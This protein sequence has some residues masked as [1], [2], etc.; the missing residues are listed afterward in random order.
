[1]KD[2]D[3]KGRFP[4][5]RW[6]PC[7]WLFLSGAVLTTSAFPVTFTV[8]VRGPNNEVVPHFRWLV[9]EDTTLV[10][11]PGQLALPGRD[12]AVSF[13]SSYCPPVGT[14]NETSMPNLPLDPAKRYYLS[15]QPMQG[16]PGSDYAIGG[17]PVVATAGVFPAI[18]T[19]LVQPLPLPTAQIS[20]FV[21]RDDSPANC[22]PDL[23][24]EVGLPG[25][26]V[27]LYE[28]GGTY[29]ASGGLVQKDAWSNPLGTTYV[30]DVNGQAVLGPDGLPIIDQL[31]SGDLITDANGECLIKN[32]FQ[33]KYSV[34]I[35]P[36]AGQNWHETTT[37]EGT[38]FNDAWVKANEPPYFQEFGPPGWHTFFGFVQPKVDTTVLAPG[39]GATINGR[40]TNLHMSRPPDYRF[41]PG[42]PRGGCWVA[43]HPMTGGVAGQSVY[44][45]PCDVNL[46][47]FSIPN[48]PEGSWSLGIWDDNLLQIFATQTVIVTAAD[49]TS[50]VKNVGD[51]SVYNW[52]HRLQAGVFTDNGRDSLDNGVT[53]F[54]NPAKAENGFWD[55][56]EQGIPET[57][58]NIRFRDGSI[59]M[60]GKTDLS[61]TFE[62][63][64]VF[65]FF[66]WMVAEVDYGKYKP[67]GGTFIVDAGGPVLPD[68]GWTYPSFD[69]LTPQKQYETDPLTGQLIFPLV[70]RIN[71]NTGNNLSFT[72]TMAT[73]TFPF[74]LQA[75]QGF[76]G[77]TNVFQW[78]KTQY[79]T[80]LGE[81]GGITGI[82]H[83]AIT[84]AEDDPR[85]AVAENWEPGIPRV[86]V[87]LYQDFNRDGIIDDINAPAGIQA[88]DVDNYPF[89]WTDPLIGLKGTEDVD[90][91]GDGVFDF[92][93]A[94]QVTWTDSWD[95]SKPTGAQPDET[96]TLY[97]MNGQPTDAYD[98][99]RN[100]NQIRPGVFDG[101]YSFQGVDGFGN[102][103]PT[104]P[105]G[106]YIVESVTP[107]G[108]KHQKEEDKN[109]V[110]GDTY[111]P[112]PQQPQP[113]C[114]GDLHLVPPY[115]ALFPDLQI[116]CY[117][118]G[119]WRPGTDR[120]QITVSPG[121]NAACDFSMFTEVPVAGH[122]VGMILDDLANEFNPN[123]PAFGEK[124]APPWIPISI[125]D[126]TGREIDRVY[127][128]E[129][130][131][132]NC[133]VPST[134]TI[135]PPFP[136][137]VS[138]NMI[139]VSLNDPG[140][141]PDPAHPGQFITDPYF[142]RQYS[143]FSYTFQ[144]LPGKTTYLD[145]PVVPT[146]AFTGP[147]QYSLDCEFPDGTPLIYA[148]SGTEYG[149]GPFV[150]ST[151]R[152]ITIT[153]LGST[154]VPN[155][156]Y[157]T[158]GPAPK[159]INRDYGFG[160]VRGEVTINGVAL[161]NVIW[162][163][164]SISGMVAAGTTTG[165]LVIRR[166]D[167][168]EYSPVGVTVT[169]GKINGR[170]PIA[171]APGGSIQAAID[172]AQPNDLILVAPGSYDQLP[173]IRKPV[174]LQG[175]GAG[176]T[177]INAR[178]TPAEKLQAWRNKIISIVN[179]GDVD[180]LP[181]Q[182]L[183]P[184]VGG[185]PALLTTEEGAG[186]TVLS[187]NA[188][189][190]NGGFGQNPRSRIDGFT[191]TGADHGGA[192]FVNG[193]A[194][195]L[196]IS[197]NRIINNAGF[198]GG[199]IRVGHPELVGDTG[200][201]DAQND[202]ILIR[203]NHIAEN[204]GQGGVGGGVSLCPGSTA[205]QVVDNFICGN[206]NQGSGGGIGHLGFNDGGLIARNTI[207]FNECF[208]QATYPTG[209]GIYVGG[210]AVVGGA[211]ALTLGTGNVT[212]DSN[213]IQGNE[214]GAG[215][216]GG[217][218]VE[219]ANGADVQAHPGD[220]NQWYA[221]DIVNNMITNN[222][223]GLAG[224][225]VALQDAA[226][227]RIVHN[228]IE[229]ND[230]TATCGLAFVVGS[231]NASTPQPA[232]VVSRA[233]S[234]GLA[235]YL[236]AN[237]FSNP[238]LVNDV[239]RLNRSFH[240]NVIP[241]APPALN[242]YQLLPDVGAGATPAYADLAVLG[243]GTAKLDPEYCA[244][245]STTGYSAT[246][247]AA[248]PVF[249]ADYVNGS[250]TQILVPEV[251]TIVVAAAF[252]EGGNFIDVHFGPLTPWDPVSLLPYSDTHI[253]STSPVIDLGNPSVESLA[254]ALSHDYDGQARW[255]GTKPD[256]GADELAPDLNR[257]G[258]VNSLDLTILFNYLNHNSPLP[259]SNP[260]WAPLDW[261]NVNHSPDGLVTAA[262][263]VLMASILAGNGF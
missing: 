83:Y 145:T 103:A 250:N 100:Y 159:S 123:A 213:I 228:A 76:L 62:F 258:K 35:V 154:P 113:V 190:A 81:N 118:A 243:A 91:N 170:N 126:W 111:V 150:S 152:S 151:G 44:I 227:V 220:P 75:F 148:V 106:T 38:N 19:V 141:I 71:P 84:R 40:V 203:Y 235:A 261:A 132:Y 1:M 244:L 31:G 201:V 21:F 175:W 225:G 20:V 157:T 191:V 51:L 2:R 147:D 64:D 252:D 241:A 162:T 85:F 251:T 23:P 219:F 198:F 26:S 133:L 155:P 163:A 93:D 135:D 144:Y 226:R 233:N 174:R 215:D 236:G 176:S 238:V 5:S 171:V 210:G 115:L 127:S 41:W 169:V 166:G 192:I 104:L 185:D 101:G 33:A 234:A 196:Q 247:T 255:W 237:S 216:G 48:V 229:N 87:N 260:F 181:N 36:P 184:A 42:E 50:G 188:T 254:A 24:E 200:D 28:A 195:Y 207:L 109:V 138:P 217:I 172:A 128:D 119:Q 60:S 114:V 256:I 89:N 6:L 112:A 248:D 121:L 177:T 108:Y 224:G 153:A 102:P 29:G 70:P 197:N 74:L 246:N 165:Q 221:V 137:G 253:L 8:D 116:P 209:G 212:I 239:I 183:G 10:G 73:T 37:I 53:F 77:A 204:G 94:V 92:G 9:E 22:E 149:G 161:T 136:S 61:G 63:E 49:V 99:L 120:K 125:R 142:L 205:Y 25:F 143:Q 18:V 105:I 12:L 46:G 186:I 4:A 88:A 139:T 158:G 117:Y 27:R 7:L 110:F 124:Y 240:F 67:T 218:R 263:L 180:L 72:E 189:P 97:Y 259:G 59:Y 178:K 14:G 58:L 107:P 140:P 129:Y 79:N 179:S 232:G 90:W 34:V 167:N 206:F 187:K 168:G 52:F 231:P 160:T 65:P 47:T 199:G 249:T 222:V 82:V 208:D 56:W 68:N 66:N 11:V 262:D 43:L 69:V 54:I 173:I 80:A 55:T 130:G 156:L 57:V 164:G 95:D 3:V 86:Q 182:A 39:G 98:G 96:G 32:L 122:I 78:G 257:D 134:Y 17:K 214:A 202:H 131:T 13:H 15:V 194:H 242:T 211:G 45:Q 30:Y 223:T 16:Q 193:Y 230:S 245:T 146:A